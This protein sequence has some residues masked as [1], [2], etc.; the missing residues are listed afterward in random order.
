M[1]KTLITKCLEEG[2]LSHSSPHPRGCIEA[3]L[4]VAW[5]DD[6][7]VPGARSNL[8]S[9]LAMLVQQIAGEAMQATMAPLFSG[10]RGPRH[11]GSSR[12]S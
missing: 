9:S 7:K 5:D 12:S 1:P 11:G 8:A 6:I 3:C 4:D 2:G 10:T